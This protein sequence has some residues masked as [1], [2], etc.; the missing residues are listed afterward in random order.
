M[1]EEFWLFVRAALEAAARQ[2]DTDTVKHWEI[3]VRAAKGV[4]S[5]GV[6]HSD[7]VND[8]GDDMT[9]EELT[10]LAQT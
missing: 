5:P 9:T 3:V 1:S 7:A 8:D 10:Q 2:L 4:P 6:A